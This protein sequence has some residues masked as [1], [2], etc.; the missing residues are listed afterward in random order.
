MSQFTE[1]WTNQPL[2]TAGDIKI[3]PFICY[4]VVYPDFVRANMRATPHSLSQSATIPGLVLAQALGNTF[5]W[6]AFA[7]LSSWRDLVRSTNDG[8]SALIQADGQI[9]ATTPQFT[10]SVIKGTLQPR[11]GQTP[12]R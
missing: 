6:R 4:E 11:S 8:V 1:G 10:Q 12:S 3:A 9:L 5:R 7:Q 2:L